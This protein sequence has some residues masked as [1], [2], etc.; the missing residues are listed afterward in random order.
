MTDWLD[1][2]EFKTAMREYWNGL[3]WHQKIDA[4]R[5]LIREK[6]TAD[7]NKKAIRELRAKVKEQQA[8]IDKLT[9]PAP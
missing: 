2:D 4:V 5:T 6:Y 8:W 3:P 1:S 9:G 7:V